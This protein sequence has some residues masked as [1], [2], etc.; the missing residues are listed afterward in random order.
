MTTVVQ[1]TN[2]NGLFSSAITAGNSVIL[3][4]IA[5]N[6][7][8]AISSSA[9]TIGGS[10]VTGAAE[11]PSENSPT[12][13]SALVYVTAWLLPNL[14][15][16]GT[17]LGLTFTATGGATEQT[18]FGIEVA[19]LGASPVWDT[20]QNAGQGA[21][22]GPATSGAS[23]AI[24]S[25]S[26]IV[27]GASVGYA[28]TVSSPGSPWTATVG[29]SGF[30]YFGYDIPGASGGSY[31][32]TTA[33]NTSGNWAAIV[34]GVLPGGGTTSG[35]AASGTAVRGRAGRP[36]RSA[37]SRAPLVR[38][39]DVPTV[40][41]GTVVKGRRGRKG[42]AQGSPQPLV[43]IEDVPPVPSGAAV[44]GR[45]GRRGNSAGSKPVP[46]ETNAPELTPAAAAGASVKGRKARKGTAAGSP[47]PAVHV[48]ELPA[49]SG[50]SVKGKPGRRGTSAG[51]KPIPV[52]SRQPQPVT[53]ASVRGKPG[54]RGKAAGSA[55]PAV[56][57][58]PPVTT[59]A[60]AS[61]ASVRGKPGRKGHLGGSP[62]PLVRL[63]V[64][65]AAAAGAAVRGRGGRKG[66]A[67]GS[68]A[69]IVAASV[70]PQQGT[71]AV[72]LGLAASVTI[73]STLAGTVT[74][75]NDL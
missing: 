2:L 28:L 34:G 7:G 13:T 1:S 73:S 22:A 66:R 9:P 30:C 6:G 69:A 3:F 17:Q 60:A 46:V 42:T 38:L 40:P 55:P 33:V 31:T 71:A 47:A 16:G 18:L 39:E 53:G 25:A 14:P 58:A 45:P 54:P 61:G 70:T 37:G 11:G 43:H 44:K 4:G 64:I 41:S 57:A 51:S 20:A 15:G 50:A 32:F 72:A 49:P 26:E 35:F 8:N 12:P 10:G 5:Y 21:N 23:G 52:Y 75:V 65:P 63:E 67:Q 27:I 56:R 74:I 62:V 29:N 48:E 36:G 24:A 19:G 59:P 68:P